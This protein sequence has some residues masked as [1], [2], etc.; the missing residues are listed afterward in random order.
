MTSAESLGGLNERA[1]QMVESRDIEIRQLRERI[2]ELENRCEDFGLQILGLRALA[3]PV[4]W[5][6]AGEL[7]EA[8]LKD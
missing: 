1:R 3:F 4:Q 7:E 2:K 8:I 6:G 5:P